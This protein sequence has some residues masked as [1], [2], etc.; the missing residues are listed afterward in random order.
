[1]ISPPQPQ[2]DWVIQ[3]QAA[4]QRIGDASVPLLRANVAV[5]NGIDVVLAAIVI[6]WI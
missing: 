3:I 6:W 5:A 1:M 4:F 2:V